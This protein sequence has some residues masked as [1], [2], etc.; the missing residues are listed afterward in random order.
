MI[1]LWPTLCDNES[2]CKASLDRSGSENPS[3]LATI[4]TQVLLRRGNMEISEHVDCLHDLTVQH[5]I[6]DCNQK[7]ANLPSGHWALLLPGVLN[8]L[9]TFVATFGFQR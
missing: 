7:S 9:K 8:G 5:L 6:N 1:K 4:L 3:L 2:T